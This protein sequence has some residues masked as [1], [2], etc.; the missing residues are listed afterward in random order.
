MA[1]EA[2]KRELRERLTQLECGA[3][4]AAEL[5][6][7]QSLEYLKNILFRYV[8]CPDAAARRPILNAIGMIVQFTPHEK[9]ALEHFLREGL[10][11]AWYNAKT[12]TI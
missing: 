9:R 4:R 11:P 6:G 3:R 1:N 2:E 10:L 12:T 5:Q 7:A 8:T